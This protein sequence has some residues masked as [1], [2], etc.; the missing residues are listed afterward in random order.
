MEVIK[1]DLLATKRYDLIE[2][3]LGH[4]FSDTYT[5][6]VPRLRLRT[7]NNI[8]Y[9]CISLWSERVYMLNINDEKIE[10]LD[11]YAENTVFMEERFDLHLS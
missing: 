10:M 7:R 8:S 11:I 6:Q 2:Q 9:N 3:N 5:R 1:A 4:R